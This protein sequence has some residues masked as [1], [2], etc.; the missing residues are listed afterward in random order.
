MGSAAQSLAN[1]LDRLGLKLQPV[2]DLLNSDMAVSVGGFM[3]QFAAYGLALGLAAGALGLGLR[4]LRGVGSALL[5]LTGIKPAWA[6]VSMLRGLGQSAAGLRSTA[7]SVERVNRAAIAAGKIQR[8][9]VWSMLLGAGLAADMVNNIPETEEGV[10]SFFEQSKARSKGWNEWLEK[11]VGTPRSWLG[12]S[13]SSNPSPEDQKRASQEDRVKDLRS[14]LNAAT[15][16]WPLAADRGMIAYGNA[17]IHGG[18]QAEA[19]AQRIGEN[20]EH[21]L[22]VTGHP[23]VNT[24]R[25]EQALSLA[26]QLAAAVKGIDTGGAPVSTPSPVKFGG[27]RAKGGPVKKGLTYLVG[28]EGPE[29]FTAGADGHITS[30]KDWR[31]SMSDAGQSSAASVT[32]HA[33]ISLDVKLQVNGSA[34]SDLKKLATQAAEEVV[35]KV[36]DA[37]DRTLNRSQQIAIGGLKPYG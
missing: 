29:P 14:Q 27:P 18:D 26:R 12:M 36:T 2:L 30:N 6:L 7:K 11:N 8:P 5:F 20:I 10:K 24:G 37:L 9:S 35:S 17:L 1:G 32:I 4:V 25:L 19:E 16:D 33:P 3:G 28:E 13:A 22:T 21:A 15:E 34:A 23:D 31:D